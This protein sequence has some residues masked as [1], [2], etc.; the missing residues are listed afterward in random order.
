MSRIDLG[1][2]AN[3]VLK[4]NP[5][6]S[7]TERIFNFNKATGKYSLSPAYDPNVIQNRVSQEEVQAF[8][9]KLLTVQLEDAPPGICMVCPFCICCVISWSNK[10]KLALQQLQG[11]ADE[12][13]TRLSSRGVY[14]KFAIA[15]FRNRRR[16]TE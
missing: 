15:E 11:I 7:P 10:T 2:Q 5:Q 1:C 3:Y 13:N 16:A 8:L 14:W 4:G 9:D 12:E 6:N